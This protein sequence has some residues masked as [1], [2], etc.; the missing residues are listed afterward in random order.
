MT[1][2]G[3]VYSLVTVVY[4][5]AIGSMTFLFMAQILSHSMKT[6]DLEDP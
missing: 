6:T 2:T 5:G 3:T 1:V 4:L